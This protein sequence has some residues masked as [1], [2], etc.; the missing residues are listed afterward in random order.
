MGDWCRAHQQGGS[1]DHVH[2]LQLSSG[3]WVRFDF[4]FFLAF[5][6]TQGE[7]LRGLCGPFTLFR[8]SAHQVLDLD[9]ADFPS[10]DHAVLSFQQGVTALEYQAVSCKFLPG[11]VCPVR[12]VLLGA[13]SCSECPGCCPL[14]AA[15]QCRDLPGGSYGLKEP[16]GNACRELGREA[17]VAIREVE[18]SG[19]MRSGFLCHVGPPP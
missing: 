11:C 12:V 7:P 2:P 3:G 14:L 4:L 17:M 8:E 13:C 19:A 18:V 10:R 6:S 5:P 1:K 15:W 9:E 16:H